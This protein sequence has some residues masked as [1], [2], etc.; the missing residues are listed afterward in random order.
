MI[1]ADERELLHQ[2]ILLDMAIRSLQQDYSALE[3]LKISKVFFPFVDDL[4]K[5]LRNDFYNKKRLL[6]Q[7]K[8]RVVKWVKISEYLSEVTIATNGEDVVLQYAKQALKT[9]VE[10]LLVSNMNK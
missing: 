7:K 2:Y 3:N 6:G 4:L 1:K 8:I 5:N 10:Q 9:Q